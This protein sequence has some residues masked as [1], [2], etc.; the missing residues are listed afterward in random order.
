MLQV[1]ERT[2]GAHADQ[3]HQATAACIGKLAALAHEL[4]GHGCHGIVLVSLH[5]DPNVSIR[6]KVYRTG[7]LVALD[8]DGVDGADVDAPA[9]Q[10]AAVGYA[11]A[12]I[13]AL[14]FHYDAARGTGA[15]A[16]TAADTGLSLIHI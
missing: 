8:R 6:V 7:G 15:N 2:L 9:A 12:A 13:G 5:E 11:G 1:T 3:R 14:A 16:A 10:D 4:E